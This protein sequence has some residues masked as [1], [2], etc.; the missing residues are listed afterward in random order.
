M[1]RSYL[2][3]AGVIAA[4]AVVLAVVGRPRH[5]EPSPVPSAPAAPVV[6]L[7]ITLL[8]DEVSPAVAAVPKGCRV[9]LRVENRGADLARLALAGYQDRLSVPVLARGVVWTGEFLADRP[10]EDFA[11][12]LDGT[13]AGRLTVAGSHLVEGHR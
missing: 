2:R 9:R 6:D 4:L 11:W 5:Q 8:K 13:P 7:A 1:T 10:G 3:L 12:L